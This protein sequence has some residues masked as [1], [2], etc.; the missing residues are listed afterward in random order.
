MTDSASSVMAKVMDEENADFAFNKH[1]YIDA[2]RTAFKAAE[3]YENING[4]YSKL[5]MQ[6]VSYD[7]TKDGE[8]WK[9]VYYYSFSKGKAYFI[10]TF[11]CKADLFEKYSKDCEELIGDF[12]KE[13][14]ETEKK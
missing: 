5:E 11:E 8:D 4:K 10:V 14:W 7:F 13:G 3:K 9:G 1:N 12:R 2:E 6:K